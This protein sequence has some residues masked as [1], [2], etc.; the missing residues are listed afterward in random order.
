MPKELISATGTIYALNNKLKNGHIRL[1]DN[2]RVSFDFSSLNPRS[3]EPQL[4][5]EVE[6]VFSHGEDGLVA[7][8]VSKQFPSDT[9]AKSSGDLT[10][11]SLFP[12]LPVPEIQTPGDLDTAT[13]A[14]ELSVQS[15]RKLYEQA[16]I[17]RAEGRFSAAR[18]LFE[19]AIANGGGADIYTAYAKMLIEGRGKDHAQARELLRKAV[20]LFPSKSTFFS[21]FGQMERRAGNLLAA[22]KILR[23]GVNL[24]PYQTLL[25]MGLA[26]VLAQMATATSLKEAGEIFDSLDAVG[27]LN[28]RDNTYTRFRALASN[29]RAGRAYSF[30]NKVAGFHPG[31]PGRRELPIGVSDLVVE[32]KDPEVDASFGVNGAYLVRCFSND[33]KR[34]DILALSKHIRSLKADSTVGL[35]NGREMVLNSSM[36]FVVIPKTSTVRDFVMSVLSENN[37]AIIPID[38]QLMQSGGEPKEKLRGLLSQ[39]LGL[40]DLYDSTLPVS[41]RR[42]FGRE[43]LLVQVAD[44][45]RRGE[46]IGIFGLRKMGKT[47]LMYQLRDEKLKEEAVAYVDLQSSPGL[48]IH[49][50][51]PV[52][53]EIERDLLDRLGPRFPHLHRILRLGVYSRYSDAAAQIASPA[54]VFSEDLRELLDEILAQRLPGVSK[55]VIVLD[56]L[57][58]CLPLA[59]QQSMSGYIEFFGLLRGLAQ[60]ERY[61]GLLSSVVVAANAAISEKAYWE[62]R[63]NPVF[64]LYKSIF[65]PPLSYED[66]AQMIHSLGKGMSVYWER[67]AIDQIFRECGGHPFLTR[68]LCSQISQR[69]L[70]RPLQVTGRMVNIEVP[71]FIQDKSDK[72]EQITELLHAHFPEEERF[73]ESLALGTQPTNVTDE[74]TR[75][76][77][78]YQLIRRTPS[79]FSMSFNA[80]TSWLKRRAGV[81]E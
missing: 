54:L 37:E 49:S 24:H 10:E 77:L 70:Q 81:A 26:Q 13:A 63:E 16:A 12:E 9:T 73:I 78:G 69:H 38:E 47:S 65:V 35:I 55:V 62:G 79:G 72:F 57:E 76:L 52:L 44:Q 53:W 67:G 34:A 74:A 14:V 2:R 75:H 28:K 80:L 60:T 6:V 25:K 17:A 15:N 29:P 22:E 48:A 3:L 71:I 43:R 46:F 23:D 36:A 4:K 19:Q 21:M 20:T 5:D 41:G 30:L 59:S 50:F 64:S 66:T 27:K 39:Y 40:R 68:M 56:E 11:P 42:L 8:A 32:I 31:I 1:F 7:D 51:L 18:E 58:R 45:A 61:G 33:P